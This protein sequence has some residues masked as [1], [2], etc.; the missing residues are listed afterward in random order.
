M[1]KLLVMQVAALLT[2]ASCG[3]AGGSLA[4][5]ADVSDPNVRAKNLMVWEVFRIFYHAV[6]KALADDNPETGWPRPPVPA[7]GSP[8]STAPGLG[9]LL[10]NPA[11]GPV[12]QQLIPGLAPPSGAKP[13]PSSTA[14]S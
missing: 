8:Q 7:A 14:G 1:D 9:G 2:E 6:V 13:T 3:N 11:L 12:L 5:S 4:I 10:S